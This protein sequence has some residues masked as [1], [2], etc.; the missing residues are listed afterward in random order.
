MI[1]EKITGFPQA[2]RDAFPVVL[3]D[4]LLHIIVSHHGMREYGCPVMPATPEAYVV[5]YNDNLDSKMSL[6]FSQMQSNDGSSRWTNFVRALDCALFKVRP[7][8]Q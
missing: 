6:T 3:R 2:H 7:N 8:E 5:H 1:E 4:S